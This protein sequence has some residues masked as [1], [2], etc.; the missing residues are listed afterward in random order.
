M[1]PAAP[2]NVAAPRLVAGRHEPRRQSHRGDERERR[3]RVV[4]KA[5]RP[6]LAQITV[7]EVG[8]DVPPHVISALEYDEVGAG[9]LGADGMRDGESGNAA[10]DDR[11]TTGRHG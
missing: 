3:G 2:E 5:V 10:A 11:D 4:E 9:R 6:C 7:D 8:A 1:E